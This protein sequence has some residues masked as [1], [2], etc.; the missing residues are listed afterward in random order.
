MP[1]LQFITCKAVN[2]NIKFLTVAN[3]SAEHYTALHSTAAHS[4]GHVDTRMCVVHH[5]RPSNQF[6]Q[7]AKSPSVCRLKLKTLYL[8]ICSVQ[9]CT[10]RFEANISECE[11]N[12]YSF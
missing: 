12:I 2:N 10:I 6:L 5:L 11:A 9:V 3:C 8:E 4:S 1:L 7:I